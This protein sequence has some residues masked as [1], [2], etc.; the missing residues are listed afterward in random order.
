M[1][2]A[3]PLTEK[4]RYLQYLIPRLN[5]AQIDDVVSMI[6]SSNKKMLNKCVPSPYADLMKM[7]GCEEAKKNLTAM[8]ADHR[9]RKIAAVRGKVQQSRAYYHAVFTGNPG[10]NKTSVA[11]MYAKALADEGIT[12]SSNFAELSRSGIV[13]QYVGATA[14]KVR[15]LWEKNAGGVI[16][17]DEAYSLND[18]QNQS[19]NNYGEEAI[20]EIIV[21]MENHPETVV[22]F[23]GYPEKMEEFLSANPGLRSRIPYHVGFSDY[24]TEELLAISNVIAEEKGFHIMLSAEE[25]LRRIFDAVKSK[26]DFGNG[27]YVRNLIESAVRTKGI[28]L[29][30]MDAVNLD[31]YITGTQYSDDLLFSLDESC[32]NIEIK[33]E[34]PV[35]RTIGFC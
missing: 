27:R 23:A 3:K 21:C 17:I 15:G 6:E 13:G 26:P 34:T 29:G 5:D 30:V 7:I 25:K 10:C 19:N 33:V 20:N 4:Q 11:R 18:G 22:I 35:K 28:Q 8:I 14:A 1:G 32:F 31:S 9:M 12:R 24:T 2:E 16:F